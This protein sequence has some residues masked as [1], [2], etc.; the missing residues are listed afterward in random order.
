[1]RSQVTEI[2]TLELS[3]INREGDQRWKLQFNVRERQE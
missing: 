2:G 1:M 3:C